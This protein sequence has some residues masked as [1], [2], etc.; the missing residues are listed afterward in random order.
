MSQ[1]E[2][3]YLLFTDSFRLDFDFISISE[4]SAYPK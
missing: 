1:A 2:G 4:T 3:F